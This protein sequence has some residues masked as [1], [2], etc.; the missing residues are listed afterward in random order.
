MAHYNQRKCEKMVNL[1]FYEVD[2]D[3]FH[4]FAKILTYVCVLFTIKPL[5]SELNPFAQRRLARFFT[6]EFCF[7][8]LHFINICVKTNKCNNYLFRLLIMHGS[9]YMF[10]HYIVILRERS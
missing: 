5:T 3:Y 6:G 9:S 4:I 8:N 7:L 1:P 10:R 2:L